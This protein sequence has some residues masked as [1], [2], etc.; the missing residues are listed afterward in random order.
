MTDQEAMASVQKVVDA[1]VSACAKAD[2]EA[3][4][5]VFH[6]D[7][8]MCGYLAG[9]RM[10]GGI[11]PFIDAVANNPPPGAEYRSQIDNIEVSG[12]I[13][14]AAGIALTFIPMAHSMAGSRSMQG[15]DRH[16]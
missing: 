10:T 2:T 5:S 8:N 15:V 9:Q 4:A 3:L 13:A 11:G 16:G 7:A 6:P 14:L 1:Y 12:N